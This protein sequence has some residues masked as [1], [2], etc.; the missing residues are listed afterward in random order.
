MEWALA[1]LPLDSLRID[2]NGTYFFTHELSEDQPQLLDASSTVITGL[3]GDD[4][5][6]IPEVQLYLSANWGVELFGRPLALIGDVT[7]RDETNTEF[8][9]DSPFNIALD[10]YTMVN[11]FAN[12][13]VT[14]NVT[15]GLYVKNA[16]DEL[17]IYDGIGTFQD[18]QA[19]ITSRPRTYGATLRWDL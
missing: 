1:F 9:T 6:N 3:E 19:I 12:M 15:I 7:Y 10:S 4:L 11:F 13:A 8:R 14:D 5:P 16:T 2:F 18:P 17:A